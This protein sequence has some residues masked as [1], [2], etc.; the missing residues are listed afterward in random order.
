MFEG[1]PIEGGQKR[2]LTK[3]E[4]LV[5]E[6]IDLRGWLHT[7]LLNP[8]IAPNITRMEEYRRVQEV[9][10]SL[11]GLL[12]GEVDVERRLHVLP[13]NPYSVNKYCQALVRLLKDARVF[14]VGRKRSRLMPIREYIQK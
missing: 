1:E 2:A 4:E 5:D 14:N 7:N 12:E 10:Y 8:H 6:F 3:T 13:Q 11:I 9:Y